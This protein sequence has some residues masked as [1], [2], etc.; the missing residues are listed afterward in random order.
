MLCALLTACVSRTERDRLR[1]QPPAKAPVTDLIHA[2]ETG[3]LILQ[4]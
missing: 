2:L 4:P 3:T 1:Q